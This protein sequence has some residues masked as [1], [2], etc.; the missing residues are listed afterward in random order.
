MLSWVIYLKIQ[1]D[2]S[3]GDFYSWNV[4]TNNIIHNTHFGKRIEIGRQFSIFSLSPFLKTGIIFAILSFSGKT[5]SGDALTFLKRMTFI[6]F[7]MTFI[8]LCHKPSY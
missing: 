1:T 7:F 8:L 4:H 2:F 6:E 5:T 3:E